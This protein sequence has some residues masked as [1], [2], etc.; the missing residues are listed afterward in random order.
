MNAATFKEELTLAVYT[1]KALARERRVT[2][3]KGM[4]E[5]RVAA[6]AACSSGDVVSGKIRCRQCGC[7][8]NAKAHLLSMTCPEGRWPRLDVG[9][10]GE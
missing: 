2:I 5:A 6:C 8:M 9:L 3:R 1:G 7:F 10:G 4:Y